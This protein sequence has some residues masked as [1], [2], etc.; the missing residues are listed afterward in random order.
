MTQSKENGAF[1]GSTQVPKDTGQ[2]AYGNSGEGAQ[3]D[4]GLSRGQSS[5]ADRGLSQQDVMDQE[6][7]GPDRSTSAQQ[8]GR[9]GSHVDESASRAVSQEQSGGQDFDR[10]GQGART[11]PDETGDHASPPV[12]DGE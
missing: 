12:L 6:N 4:T 7:A 8:S 9:A 5:A 2:A 1:S 11:S 3:P 10:D